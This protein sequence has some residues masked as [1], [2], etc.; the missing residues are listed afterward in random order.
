M[1]AR[2]YFKAISDSD[3]PYQEAAFIHPASSIALGYGT[4]ESERI[5]LETDSK[6][7]QLQGRYHN[8]SHGWYVSAGL[9]RE[10]ST[11]RVGPQGIFA[12][13]DNPSIVAGA[14]L[15]QQP[16]T[17]SQTDTDSNYYSLGLGRYFGAST[18]LSLG[19][20]RI[21]SNADRRSTSCFTDSLI[22]DVGTP[23]NCFDSPFSTRIDG[24]TNRWQVV[25]RHLRE[26]AHMH[27]ALRGGVGYLKSSSD[28][29]RRFS[30]DNL[31]EPFEAININSDTAPG[32]IGAASLP[33]TDIDNPQTVSVTREGWNATAEITLYPR[34]NL[35]LAISYAYTDIEDVETKA[36]GTALEWFVTCSVSVALRYTDT[37]FGNNRGNSDSTALHI[38]GRF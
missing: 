6:T 19:Y 31:G 2:Y 18:T 4:N 10:E 36:Y 22:T 30:R 5:A 11:S 20:T 26:L 14:T 16:I 23:L 15:F 34:N 21:E 29:E 24:E 28:F 25:A 7:W 9:S 1:G 33:F 38:S 12:A 17:S 35:G 13:L 27:L 8:R 37:D 32:P 3:G